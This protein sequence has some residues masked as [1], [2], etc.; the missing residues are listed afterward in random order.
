MPHVYKWRWKNLKRQEQC[1]DNLLIQWSNDTGHLLSRA[2]YP[3]GWNNKS[4]QNFF[5]MRNTFLFFLVDLS[6]ALRGRAETTH[7]ISRWENRYVSVRREA[8]SACS[9]TVWAVATGVLYGLAWAGWVFFY[10]FRLRASDASKVSLAH[11]FVH[12]R[13]NL[14]ILWSQ[15][16]LKIKEKSRMHKLKRWSAMF[17]I[18][19]VLA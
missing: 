13:H 1:S 11:D 14:R 15:C 3:K 6:S 12:T 18:A 7:T 4:S 17:S 10:L 9:E 16:P 8:E 5:T 2:N 19:Q